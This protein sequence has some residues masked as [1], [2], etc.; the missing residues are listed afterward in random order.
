MRTWK[1]SPRIWLTLICLII[2]AV[3][4]WLYHNE[5]RLAQAE[6]RARDWL[7]TNGAAHRSPRHPDIV[8]LG[9]DSATTSLDEVFEDDIAQSRALQIIKAGD[10]KA[11]KPWDRELYA[12]IAERLIG[13][14][15]K[16]VVFDITFTNE[17][18]GDPAFRAALD[19]F[20]DRVV[21]GINLT[22]RQDEATDGVTLSDTPYLELPARTLI[23]DGARDRRVGFVNVRTDHDGIVRRVHYRTTLLEWFG[24]PPTDTSPELLSLPASTLRQVGL[25][26]LV[27]PGREPLR[28]RFPEEFFPRSLYEIFVEGIW[29][30]PPYNRGEL[31]RDKIVL[32]GQS[33]NQAEDR[34]IT[35]LGTVLGPSVHLAALNAA[36]NGDFLHELPI[37]GDFAL[38]VAA[39]VVAWMLGAWVKRPVVRVALLVG[40]ALVYFLGAQVLF[41]VAGI[42]LLLLAPTIALLG[43]GFTW[44]AWEQAIDREERKRI[45]RT[46]EGYVSRDVVREVLDN[47][48]SFLNTQG[49]A[50][51]CITVLFSDVRGFTTMTESADA[52]ALV[53]QLNEYFTEMVRIVFARLGTLDKFIGDAVMAHWGSVTSHGREADACRAVAAGLDMFKALERLN[54]GWRTRGMIELKVGLGINHGEAIVGRI[55]S[56]DKHEFSAIGD[57]INLASRLEGATKQFHQQ[58]L[59]GESVAPMVRDQFVIRTVGLIQVKGKTK[60][61]EVFTAL[62]ERS[63]AGEP[64]WLGPYE[65]GVKLYRRR[66]FAEAVECFQK[67]AALNPDDWL[68][69]AYQ[70]WCADYVTTP[71]APEWDGVYVMADK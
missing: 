42:E 25:E 20:T 10:P 36:L 35:P 40:T 65:E 23:E 8:F 15:A 34:I 58:I 50:R 14:G 37:W 6:L 66:A 28:I 12:M 18:N 13:A 56:E 61:V 31:F 26:H 33:G 32:I 17:R 19:R 7:A 39:G 68:I 21:L 27:P 22:T 16:V 38:I 29:S 2:T 45:R 52:E 51:R 24:Y 60:P 43:S 54:A 44:S 59:I 3:I 57:P 62:S 30:R 69:G 70:R 4:A 41:N 55:G 5:E 49:G 46:L 48:Q 11:G 63:A 64:P 71:P 47:P 53:T 1:P 67:A 9:I